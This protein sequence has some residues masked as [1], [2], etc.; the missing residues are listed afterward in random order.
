M[1]GK[2]AYRLEVR[3]A[4]FAM[5]FTVAYL[6]W[7]LTHGGVASHHFLDR[8]S[9]PAISNWWGLG[10]LPL[11]GWLAAWSVRRRAAADRT[12]PAKAAAAACGAFVV[13]VAMCVSFTMDGS[14]NV[15]GYVFLAALAS[16]LWFRTYRAEYVFGF[17][18]GMS[19]V[20][21]L[22]LPAIVSLVPVTISAAFHLLVRPAF[23]WTLRR[24]RSG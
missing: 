4:G 3:V 11:I 8:R 2:V 23:A 16:G 12:E 22:A 5:L 18:I 10:I 14:G 21:G 24:A 17:V 13:G 6:A 1:A 19:F 20:F 7:Q 9:M 15:P